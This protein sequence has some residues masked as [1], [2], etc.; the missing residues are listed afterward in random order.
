MKHVSLDGTLDL[1]TGF[2][3]S[4]ADSRKDGSKIF[5]PS[6]GGHPFVPATSI[7]G[8]LRH[9]NT[10][11]V[12]EKLKE[13]NIL[14][15]LN[16]LFFN[17][18]GGIKES[19]DSNFDVLTERS[20][21]LQHPIAG[22]YG[23][24]EPLFLKGKIQIENALVNGH[25]TPDV[26]SG[27]RNDPIQKGEITREDVSDHDQFDSYIEKLSSNREKRK[28]KDKDTSALKPI[29][30]NMPHSREIIPPGT[31]CSHS[32]S[33]SYP[34]EIELGMFFATLRRFATSA[35][36]FGAQLG[37]N[38]G[39]VDVEYEVSVDGETIGSISINGRKRTIEMD[40]AVKAYEDG[41][42][43]NFSNIQFQ[44]PV[45]KKEK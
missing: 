19:G 28:E 20:T 30:T 3:V 16:D 36:F 43:E 12:M 22:L 38:L 1:L 33:I 41:F 32:I 35:P 42:W 23:V 44:R 15:T 26:V 18:M 6:L 29:S 5:L 2:T 13:K 8:K 39:I 14:F 31:T 45:F 11:M 40:S 9:L 24:S 17:S 34:T 10:A 27:Q 4:Y 25:V 21:L 7:K 37:M